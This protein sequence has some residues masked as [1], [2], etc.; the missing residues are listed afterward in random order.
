MASFHTHVTVGFLAS[1]ILASGAL[2]IGLANP[3]EAVIC[4]GLGTLGSLLADIDADNSIPT[5]VAVGLLAITIA[6]AIIFFLDHK[7]LALIYLLGIWFVSFI[8][9]RFLIFAIVTKI[10][11]HRGLFHSVPAA[12]FWGLGI[13]AIATYVLNQPPQRAW[14]VGSFGTLGYLVHLLLDEVYSVDWDNQR[15]KRSFGS[16]FKLWYS[17]NWGGIIALYIVCVGMY[18][19]N[20][21]PKPFLNALHASVKIWIDF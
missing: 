7:G 21:S 20:P 17:A 10:T 11:V 1:G 5:R 16:A 19:I 2:I 12:M 9:L 15:I 13:V 3:V 4:W 6:F 8:L 18:F 14:L